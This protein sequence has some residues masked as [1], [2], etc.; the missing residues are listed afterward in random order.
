M[1]ETE[2]KMGPSAHNRFFSPPFIHILE[3]RWLKH[4]GTSSDEY[5]LEKGSSSHPGTEF[6]NYSYERSKFGLALEYLYKSGKINNRTGLF[7]EQRYMK[8]N[9]PEE[10][11]ERALFKEQILEGVDVGVIGGPEARFFADMGANAV[12]IDPLIARAPPVDIPHLTEL[13]ENLGK[14]VAQ[15]FAGAFDLTYSS[16]VFDQRSGL[17]Q[18]F[19]MGFIEPSEREIEVYQ[20]YLRHIAQMTKKG[21][22]SLHD[23]NMMVH[24][25][26]GNQNL[27]SVMEISPISDDDS[28]NYGYGICN[29]FTIFVLKKEELPSAL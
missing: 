17:D 2:F 13:S 7:D 8:V 22:I 20:N 11:L 1:R 27:F 24:A 9:L 19:R 25:V 15:R 14:D 5:V 28:L 21:G 6:M 12:S 3:Q 4:F 18:I 16:R 29:S 10:Q 23:G 26:K